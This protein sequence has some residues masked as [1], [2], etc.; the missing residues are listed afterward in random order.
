MKNF[1]ALTK[2]SLSFGV[3]LSGLL[4]FFM[5]SGAY[6]SVIIPVF[7][8]ILLLSM[9]ICA[10][11]EVQEI[12]LD[13]KMTRT[14]NRPLVTQA[15]SINQA[16]VVI[17]VLMIPSFIMIY[18]SI[19]LMGFNIFV[20]SLIVYNGIY[21]PLKQKTAFAVVPGA[22]L[23][24]S[25]PA[26]GWLAGG[27]NLQDYDFLALALMMFVWQMPHFWLL[28]LMY[29]EDY[30]KA[31]FPL[32]IELFGKLGLIRVTF[33]WYLLTLLAG[34]ALVYAVAPQNL[35]ILVLSVVATLYYIYRSSKLLDTKQLKDKKDYRKFFMDL[36][37][38]V[39]L[40]MLLLAIDRT[41]FTT[42]I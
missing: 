8:A 6:M 10:L 7:F 31:K 26:V 39:T 1:L 9:A 18:Q 27:G 41:F 28:T 35:I 3:A 12:N 22:L 14:Q 20:F 16:L 13:A 29:Y 42:I 4:S 37:I 19:G 33:I 2:F 34:L 24:I 21:T 36:N 17:V 38:F 11:N 32:A 30:Q 25:A 5:A 40:I 23:G 15:I